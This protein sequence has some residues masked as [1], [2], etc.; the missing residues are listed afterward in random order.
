MGL[1][2]AGI[3]ILCQEVRVFDGL[4]MAGTPCPYM[5]KI[6]DAAK[7]SWLANPDQSPEGSLIR[8]AAKQAA[9]LSVKKTA[10]VVEENDDFEE[11]SD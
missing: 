11:Y 5:G 2:V 9:A 8:V 7:E 3:S 10:P 6:G 4:W 1:K